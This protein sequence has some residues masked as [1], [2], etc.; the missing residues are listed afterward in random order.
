MC[1]EAA[2]EHYCDKMSAVINFTE[3]HNNSPVELL[4]MIHPT[5]G[6]SPA[7]PPTCHRLR[8]PG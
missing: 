7:L 1:E 8:V 6:P 3:T 2:K 5:D 4:G